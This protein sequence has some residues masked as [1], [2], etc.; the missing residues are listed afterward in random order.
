MSMPTLDWTL[1]AVALLPCGSLVA[2]ALITPRISRPDLFF[3]VTVNPSFRRSPEGREIL[4]RYDWSVLAVALAA[5]LLITIA[6]LRTPAGLLVVVLGTLVL[7]LAGWFG[8]FVAAR[9]RT[10]PHHVEP[11]AEREAA[12]RPRR[13]SLPGGWPAQAGPFLILAAIC[14]S[15]WL[16]W[17]RIPSRIPIHW[18]LTGHP[19]GWSAKSIASVFGGAAVGALI[20]SLTAILCLMIMGGVRRIHG[21]GPRARRADRFLRIMS[22]YL[23]ALEYWFALL[24]GLIC[25]TALRPDPAAPLPLFWPIMVAQTLVI[26]TVFLLVIRSGQGGWR[27]K[28][29]GEGPA[30][31]A[32]VAP[33][34][35]RT[36]DSCWK[37]GLFYFNRDDPALIVEKRFGAGWTL[38]FGN[39]RALLVIGGL[40]VFILAMLALS[41]MIAKSGSAAA[42]G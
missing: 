29:V 39:P 42:R 16:R 1:I 21:S 32:D 26:G 11:A 18:G 4:R 10:L 23:L 34:G 30:P 19:D 25:L 14:A 33:V 8:A 6:P 37:L 38:N 22:L 27:L 31:G 7:E 2:A 13:V 20:C 36:P 15:L 40:L 9:R 28:G 3:A 17:D 35:D 12:M 5:L 24:M 41:L